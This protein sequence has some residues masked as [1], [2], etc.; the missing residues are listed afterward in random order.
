M[1]MKE[2]IRRLQLELEGKFKVKLD[3]HE[4]HKKLENLL[5]ERS[6]PY[7]PDVRTIKRVFDMVNKTKHQIDSEEVRKEHKPYLATREA[8]V[9]LLDYTSWADFESNL[10]HN[11]CDGNLFDPSAIDISSLKLGEVV[12]LGWKTSYYFDV[13][14]LGDNSFMIV[15]SS[16]PYCHIG[17]KFRA[18]RF[19]VCSM[20][21]PNTKKDEYG[22]I[23][24]PRI[25]YK[26]RASILAVIDES[27]FE[28]LDDFIML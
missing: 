28:D 6:M 26:M 19:E 14:Y 11:Y 13:E 8:L 4:G 3:C 17:K 23:K 20:I 7:I 16:E 18:N 10:E 27:N 15:R 9:K 5:K 1:E 2:K 25:G 21:Y 22:N 12:T 24:L